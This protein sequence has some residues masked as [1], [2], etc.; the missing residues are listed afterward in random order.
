MADC[1]EEQRIKAELFSYSAL[2][3]KRVDGASFHF[4]V[5][6]GCGR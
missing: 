4:R 5:H 2:R 3:R 6:Q 1:Q